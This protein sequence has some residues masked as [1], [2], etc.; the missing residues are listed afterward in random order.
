MLST[1]ITGTTSSTARGPGARVRA[2]PVTLAC[3][4]YRGHQGS[5]YVC[6]ADTLTGVRLTGLVDPVEGEP[7]RL[8]RHAPRTFRSIDALLADHVPDVALVT[9]PHGQHYET[10]A[11]LV[12]AGSHVLVEKPLVPDVAS[13]ARLLDIATASGRSI[14]TLTQRPTRP[15]FR[16]LQRALEL[17]EEPYWAEWSYSMAFD[18]PTRGWRSEWSQARG[19]VLLDMGYHALDVLTQVFGTPRVL[20]A[21]KHFR[22]A[23]SRSEDLEDLVSASLEFLDGAVGGHLFVARHAREK[24]E[25]LEVHGTRGVASVD[26]RGARVDVHAADGTLLDRYQGP[27]RCTDSPAVVLSAY[28]DLA[29]RPER[30]AEHLRHHLAVVRSCEEIYRA[31]AHAGPTGLR[32]AARSEHHRPDAPEETTTR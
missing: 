26:V 18:A 29:A 22:Y 4:G 11:R 20:G 28:L 14:V 8:R 24:R 2:R 17:I 15:E 30:A 19:G 27:A 1:T 23:E 10:I 16:Y 6:A 31:A 12:D 7:P 3:V 5:E 25:V 9:V 21:S 32:G 13:A